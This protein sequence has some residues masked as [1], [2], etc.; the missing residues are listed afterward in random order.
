MS[1]A[2]RKEITTLWDDM[3]AVDEIAVIVGLPDDVVALVVEMHEHDK[4]GAMA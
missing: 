1:N 3:L 4:V 2:L